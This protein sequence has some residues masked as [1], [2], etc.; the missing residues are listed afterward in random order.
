M[1]SHCLL[2]DFGAVFYVSVI[3]QQFRLNLK[4]F[5]FDPKRSNWVL[6]NTP[7]SAIMVAYQVSE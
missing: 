2:G 7:K 6:T 5:S 3:V 4:T 1:I